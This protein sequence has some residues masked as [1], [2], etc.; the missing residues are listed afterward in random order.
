MDAVEGPH[1]LKA[2]TNNTT[3]STTTTVV[4]TT[5]DNNSQ[6]QPGINRLTVKKNLPKKSDTY[7]HILLLLPS[8]RL[9]PT[10][11]VAVR[12]RPLNNKE[13][14]RENVSIIARCI[15]DQTVIVND[16]SEDYLDI[17]RKDRNRDRI[18]SFDGKLK[19]SLYTFESFF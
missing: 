14:N 8:P 16:P 9:L 10:L 7:S 12:I 1:H 3:L 18:Y 11:K 17:L 19:G 13:L 4:A 6:Q 5:G 15:D 2:A